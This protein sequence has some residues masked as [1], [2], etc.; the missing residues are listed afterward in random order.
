MYYNQLKDIQ[1]DLDAK[2]A[3]LAPVSKEWLKVSIPK[4]EADRA[5]A[6]AHYQKEEDKIFQ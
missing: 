3:L 4:A 5:A 2:K 6:L 1:K